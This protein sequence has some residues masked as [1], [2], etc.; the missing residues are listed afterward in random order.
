M[1]DHF[2]FSIYLSK[3]CHSETR[4][5]IR[6]ISKFSKSLISFIYLIMSV[7]F[8]KVALYNRKYPLI[9]GMLSYAALWPISSLIQQKIIGKEKLDYVQAARFC[10]YGSLFVAPTLYLWIRTTSLLWPG[11]SLKTALTKVKKTY[12]SIFLKISFC[13]E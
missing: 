6:S 5:R 10:I 12:L 11:N 9:K 1:Q 2:L 13:R 8:S 3:I 7:V 4:F